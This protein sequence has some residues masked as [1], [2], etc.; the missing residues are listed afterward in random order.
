MQMSENAWL[1]CIDPRPMLNHLRSRISER[2]V[3]LFACACCRRIWPWLEEC[4]RRAV[5]VAELFADNDA[6]QEQ[7]A[8]ARQAT[9]NIFR[10][11]VGR[12]Q[13]AAAAAISAAS[14]VGRR[15]RFWQRLLHMIDVAPDPWHGP[16]ESGDTLAPA[17]EASRS[18]AWCRA[19]EESGYCKPIPIDDAPETVLE[20]RHQADVLRH[21]I[22]NP[23]RQ[24]GRL[25]LLPDR[26]VQLAESIYSGKD[27]AFALHDAL[28][29]AGKTD[30][31]QH[32]C[33]AHHPKGCWALDLILST[34][35]KGQ[36][37]SKMESGS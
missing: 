21:V 7:L 23:F 2:K 14:L 6:T 25:D 26:V 8:Q 19:M 3:R 18:S 32:F 4:G 28:I 12:R 22:G 36:D 24:Y 27:C 1:D 15:P 11:L 13:E 30:L 29:E 20:R 33:Q 5:E 35:R 9:V 34:A 10:Q 17:L 37:S 31:A 16:F